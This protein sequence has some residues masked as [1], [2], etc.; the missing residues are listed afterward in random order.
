MTKPRLA[1]LALFVLALAVTAAFAGRERKTP[2]PQEGLLPGEARSQVA[3]QPESGDLVPME[4]K[5]LDADTRNALRRDTEGL[6]P[7]YHADGSVS[8]NLEGRFQT[9]SVARLD[10]DGRPVI[11]CIESPNAAS[12]PAPALEV[13]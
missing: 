5:E 1:A 8:V 3:I 11:T 7:V 13:K 9:A 4:L 2:T 6:V 12:A 10:A